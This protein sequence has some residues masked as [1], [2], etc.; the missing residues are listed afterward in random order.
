L[1]L[2]FIIK[3]FKSSLYAPKFYFFTEP[4]FSLYSPITPKHVTSGNTM[5]FFTEPNL[6]LYS[7]YYAEASNE[8]TVPI[9]AP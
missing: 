9:L 4:N 7:H 2:V 8:F 5:Y 3:A 6:S 1:A